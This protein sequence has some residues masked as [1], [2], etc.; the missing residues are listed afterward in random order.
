MKEIS[1]LYKNLNI[2]NF[3]VIDRREVSIFHIH[4]MDFQ[5]HRR[6]PDPHIYVHLWGSQAVSHS[7]FLFLFFNAS[8]LFSL[9]SYFLYQCKTCNINV[10]REV[11][12]VEVLLNQSFFFLF[13]P[14]LPYALHC[15][16]EDVSFYFY[17][18]ALLLV[19]NS[20]KDILLFK[21]KK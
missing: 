19:A 2:M 4:V 6:I 8:F 11:T 9:V 12:Y 14:F 20:N 18:N 1:T 21:K 10:N 15:F 5:R 17:L 16:V 13:F 3:H 7:F